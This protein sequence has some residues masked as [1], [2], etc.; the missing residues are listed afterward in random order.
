MP[1]AWP[2]PIRARPSRSMGSDVLPL[3]QRI[4]VMTIRGAENEGEPQVAPQKE[5][6]G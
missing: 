1:S 6:D 3:R 5:A 4:P 2:S